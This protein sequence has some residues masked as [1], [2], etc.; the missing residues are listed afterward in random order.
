[1]ACK[2][3]IPF[4][5]NTYEVNASVN[6]INLVESCLISALINLLAYKNLNM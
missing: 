3:F 2:T 4:S 5:A 6:M 1:M